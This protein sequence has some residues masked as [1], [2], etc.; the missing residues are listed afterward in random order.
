M[1]FCSGPY[2]SL[3]TIKE[4]FQGKTVN[5]LIYNGS[6]IL[7]ACFDLKSFPDAPSHFHITDSN[8][9]GQIIRTATQHQYSF[10]VFTHE[11]RQEWYFR[12][13]YAVDYINDHPTVVNEY[14]VKAII[15]LAQKSQEDIERPDLSHIRAQLPPAPAA[16]QQTRQEIKQAISEEINAQKSKRTVNTVRVESFELISRVS[17]EYLYRLELSH[18]AAIYADQPIKLKLV[19]DQQL[20]Q[21]EGR[22]VEVDGF[23]IIVAL[24][25]QL[26]QQEARVSQ[27]EFDPTFILEALDKCLIGKDWL[28]SLH[29]STIL[30]RAL[31]D[32]A[33]LETEVADLPDLN[34]R[35]NSALYKAKSR[36]I[37]MIWGPPG[38][39]KTTTLGRLVHQQL[40]SGLRCLLLSI[41]NVAVD[42]LMLAV[43]DSVPTFMEPKLIRTGTTRNSRLEHFTSRNKILTSNPEIRRRLQNYDQEIERL[44][45]ELKEL[46]REFDSLQIESERRRKLDR[47]ISAVFVERE[48]MKQKRS[49]ESGAIT[50]YEES[51]LLE[52][53]CVASTLANLVLSESLQQQ[54]FDAVFVDE[55]SMVPITFI[56]AAA[57]KTGAFLTLAGDPEQLPPI[58][59]SNSLNCRKWLGRN[60][61]RF[62]NVGQPDTNENV[63]FLNQ[64]YRM[65]ESISQLVSNLSYSGRLKSEVV[66]SQEDEIIFLQI[67][68]NPTKG[69]YGEHYSVRE[70]SYYYPFSAFVL[71]ALLGARPDLRQYEIILLSPFRAQEILLGKLA[72]DLQLNQATSQTI[73]RSQGSETDVVILDLTIHDP[74]TKHPFFYDGRP[75][76]LINVA[77]SRP[78]K[79][80]IVLAN[81][82][83]LLSLGEQDDFFKNMYHQ[84]QPH[85]GN[86][87]EVLRNVGSHLGQMKVNQWWENISAAKGS[88]YATSLGDSD[89]RIEAVA[90][91]LKRIDLD[92]PFISIRSGQKMID[93][94]GVRLSANEE[95]RIIPPMAIA[96]SD[97]FINRG[98]QW[99]GAKLPK[100]A[101]SLKS[102]ALGHKIE[103]PIELELAKC[104]ICGHSLEMVR[105]KDLISMKCSGYDCD[106][107]KRI[108]R[109]DVMN[110]VE[111][112]GKK[113]PKCSTKMVVRERKM[114]YHEDR[115]FLACPNYPLCDGTCSLF[116]LVD[117]D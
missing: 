21:V 53:T 61:F 63:T 76:K 75:Q 27:I 30:N 26:N 110:L 113:C 109:K 20:E 84:L 11:K 98:S 64:Q 4:H 46:S 105:I 7:C 23:A 93:H 79:K 115:Y 32:M 48:K 38:T 25:S 83:Q 77:M 24:E 15:F 88:I 94:S 37:H 101:V 106:Y 33:N 73:H 42:Q 89:I 17:V 51:A 67:D 104:R 29:G 55:I 117:Y 68:A 1:L 40:C 62:L 97:V 87:K 54:E 43:L 116:H 72:S 111:T 47:L 34:Q 96:G 8:R 12:G 16:N 35:Q 65:Q 57:Y 99:Y 19:G 71:E 6:D 107:T 100:M 39:G 82:N 80:L 102:I 86:S 81:K 69:K 2:Y 50:Q 92:S 5:G 22:V 14:G 9:L 70:K 28:D 112:R 52:S 74:N 3:R 10:P 36:A 114:G 108:S 95:I 59:V 103:D 85:I 90:E 56:L 49:I 60:L 31:P 91:A 78:K 66:K 58:L 41:S 45:T 18:K 44:S 13:T